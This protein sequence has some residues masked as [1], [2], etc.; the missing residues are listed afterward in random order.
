MRY[1][2]NK[3]GIVYAIDIKHA[4]HIAEYYR[5][6]GLNAVAISS[7]TPAEERK[8]IIEIFRNT[9]DHELS[10]DLNTNDH[11]LSTNLTTNCHELSSN[12][13]QFKTQN[14]KL[15]ILIT[16]DLFGEGFD[17][18]DVE[19]IQLARPTLSLAKYLQQ[20]GRGMRVFEGKKFCL[21]L[22]NVGLYRLF[23]LPSDERDWQ[24]MFEGQIAGKG[25]I[26]QAEE[27]YGV[28]AY[29]IRDERQ[30]RLS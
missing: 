29:S 27:Q 12:C 24:S 1:A 17:C 14:S 16:V 8:R 28:V 23:G 18:P 15:N 3:K 2:P 7:K 22:D 19:F 26:T 5:E 25:N 10:N 11:E 30:S 20:V 6:H 9:N 4:E 13:R 21:I